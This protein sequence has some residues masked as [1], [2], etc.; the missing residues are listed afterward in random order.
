MSTMSIADIRVGSRCRSEMGDIAGLA[1]SIADVGLL[2]P[3]V[4]TPERDLIAGA[5][6]LAACQLLG[7][8]DVPVT[9][10]ALEE[11]LRGEQAENTQRKG[12][13]PTE[14][15]A[16]GRALEPMVREQAR[17]RQAAGLLAGSE[18]RPVPVN[19]RNG[20]TQGEAREI[21]A[22]AV[23]MSGATY[24]RARAVVAA[25]EA[26]PETFGPI[27][28]EMDRTG[29][30]LPAFSA[31]QKVRQESSGLSAPFKGR[32]A[33]QGRR[34]RMVEMAREGYHERAI[35]DAVGVREDAVRDHLSR[36]GV[37]TL[38]SRVG[39]LPRLDAD[40][41][42]EGIV[43]AAEPSDVAIKSLNVGDLDRSRLDVWE[44]R[45][46]GAIRALSALR[47]KVREEMQK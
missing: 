2:H 44:E 9:V 19:Y 17:E 46:T 14:A 6:R 31:V 45:L 41:T 10:V 4:V 26:D 21:V 34:E 36:V 22:R 23:G 38:A 35:A 30:V 24:E 5:R 33:T 25:A 7:W 11:V 8:R 13:T 18:G 3:V 37:P 16:I 1:R 47:A 39:K 27:V 20:D 15:V 29:R 12:F 32:A 42:M 43:T 40:R 28:E